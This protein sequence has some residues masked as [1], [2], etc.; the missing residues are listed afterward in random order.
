MG[1]RGPMVSLIGIVTLR[2]GGPKPPPRPAWGTRT[3][4]VAVGAG[5]V[6]ILVRRAIPGVR[7][8]LR[9]TAVPGHGHM[10]PL[11][12]CPCRPSCSPDTHR[13][14]SRLLSG[15]VEGKAEGRCSGIDRWPDFALV[16]SW[17]VALAI[18]LEEKDTVSCGIY[19]RDTLSCFGLT[20]LDPCWAEGLFHIR[21]AAGLFHIR[22]AA[23]PSQ[24]AHSGILFPDPGAGRLGQGTA[25]FP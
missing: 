13:R 21:P 2:D 12:T 23:R 1:C 14:C 3:R 8:C 16:R 18:L 7:C 19:K 11:R 24:A 6:V 4:A 10:R 22:P 15:P 20:S 25:H 17:A 5:A 9:T